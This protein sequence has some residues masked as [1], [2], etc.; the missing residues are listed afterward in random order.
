MS[1]SE[2]EALLLTQVR[3]V[4]GFTDKN[5]S[6]GDWSIMNDGPSNVYAILRPGAFSQMAA[7][8]RIEVQWLTVIEIWQRYTQDGGTAIALQENMYLV[9]RRLD[10]YSHAGDATNTIDVAGVTGG[11]DLVRVPA[12]GGPQWLVWELVVRWQEQ[13]AKTYA[14]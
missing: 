11:N 5:T 9:K 12:G 1:Y 10:E 7:S 2:G 8:A 13:E 4:P 3:H 6:R 14:D